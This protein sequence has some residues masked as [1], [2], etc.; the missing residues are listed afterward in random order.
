[1][2]VSIDISDSYIKIVEGEQQGNKIKINKAI[3]KPIDISY[4]NNGY[5]VNKTDLTLF[6]T[7]I[8]NEHKLKNKDC[9]ITINSTDTVTKEITLPKTKTNH[10]QKLIKNSIKELF[11]DTV[12][13]CI[14]YQIYEEIKKEGKTFYKIFIYGVPLKIVNDLRSI[15]SNAGLV[16]KCLDIK[17]NAISKIL[18]YK[19]N[20]NDIK[21]QITLFIEISG[22][23]MVLNLMHGNVALYKRDINISEDIKREQLFLNRENKEEI[24]EDDNSILQEV[25]LTVV[26]N[27]DE[28]TFL[29]DDQDYFE[30]EASFI[31]PILLRTYEEINKI[32]Q[33]AMSLNSGNIEKIYLYG[34]R[35]NI[36][37]I[38]EY[39][40]A[41]VM[42]ETEKI[43]EI[44]NI[45]CDEDIEVAKFFNAIGNIL[46]K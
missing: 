43:K 12:N 28:I 29:D 42:S 2:P 19:I 3:S 10:L 17:R 46:R 15:I 21:K 38:A 16:P 9:F 18:E 40:S 41:N 27:D 5:I 26:K 35:E 31:S 34:D 33:F 37:E 20:N 8:V 6:L 23:N 24:R 11:G 4:I 25:A 44:A 14:D 30:E 22:K 32:I 7:D 39:I 36:E 1:M 13:L 45:K